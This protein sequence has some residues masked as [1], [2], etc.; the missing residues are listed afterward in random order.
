M[1]KEKLGNEGQYAMEG[2]GR[3]PCDLSAR[4]LVWLLSAVLSSASWKQTMPNSPLQGQVTQHG[5]AC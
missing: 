2:R 4:L 3:S 5:P 1:L